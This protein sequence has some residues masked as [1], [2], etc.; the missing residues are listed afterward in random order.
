MNQQPSNTNPTKKQLTDC[1]KVEINL[2]LSQLNRV[3]RISLEDF[4]TKIATKNSRN[5][6]V[7]CTGLDK[8]S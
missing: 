5:N 3:E 8:P 4:L 6:R 2:G 1:E 7:T